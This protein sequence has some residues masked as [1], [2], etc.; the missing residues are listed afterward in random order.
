MDDA[1][2]R[3]LQGAAQM[4]RIY[5][6]STSAFLAAQ[7]QSMQ[8]I[9]DE[10]FCLS[11]GAVNMK[12]WRIETK[13][14]RPVQQH[15]KSKAK[16]SILGTR[17]AIRRCD[18]CSRVSKQSLDHP[19]K[20]TKPPKVDPLHALQERKDYKVPSEA[21]MV[22]QSKLSSKKRAKARKDREGLQALLDRS[23]SDRLSSRLTLT[24]LMKL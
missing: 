7:K 19:P 4:M 3:F 8:E 18:V 9:P 5:S 16:N 15:Y 14:T 20:L 11:C 13:Q 6:P 2:E 10:Y 17:F 1:R 23:K 21:S 12:A 22:S 24:D